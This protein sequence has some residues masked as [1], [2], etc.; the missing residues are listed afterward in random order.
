M[1]KKSAKVREVQEVGCSLAIA[2]ANRKISRSS[3]QVAWFTKKDAEIK[4]RK[5]RKGFFLPCAS[6]LCDLCVKIM[7]GESTK[8]QEH[9][10]KKAFCLPPLKTSLNT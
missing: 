3:T 2:K 10:R 5:D 9:K 4:I 8:E 6:C 7:S 1:P